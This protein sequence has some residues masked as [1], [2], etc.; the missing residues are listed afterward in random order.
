MQAY[1]IRD[2]FGLDELVCVERPQPE[3]GPGQVR[4]RVSAVSLNYRDLMM[5]RGEYNPRQPLPLVPCSDGV[6][7]IEALG[8]GVQGLK[9]G[10]RVA[11]LFAQ[12]WLDGPPT[13]DALRSTL[14]GPIDGMLAQQVVLDAH[15]VAPVPEHLDDVEAATLPCAALTAW[16][17]LVTLGNLHAGDVVLVQGSGGVSTFALD[18][19]CMHGA[20][21][22]ATTG[23]AHKAQGLRQRG[24]WQVIDHRNV[25]QW[26]KAARVL[27]GG[28]GV[29]HVVEVGGV[30]TMAQS[31]RAVR[32]GGTISLIGVLAGGNA[33]LSLTPALMTQV[34]IQGVF[35][36]HRAS[37]LAMG[38]AITQHGLRPMVDRT[39]SFGEAR[40]AFEHVASGAHQGK[41]CIRL[42]E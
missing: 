29:D 14:G 19:A 6:G 21:V 39:F 5:V 23:S 11:G 13:A 31:L 3:P 35:V 7:T 16:S 20:R 15:G 34:R 2:G 36:G 8:P 42:T 26:G 12:R 38:K 1:E 41:V 25:P 37:F 9:E 33:D 4:V 22:I 24:A 28:E 27:T 40:A 32:P 30:G 10:D 18:F 17:A